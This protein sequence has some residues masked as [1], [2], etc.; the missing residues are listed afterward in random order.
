MDEARALAIVATAALAAAA[1]TPFV[2]RLARRIGAVDRPNER[3]VSRREAMPLMG[4]LAVGVGCAVGVGVA[5]ALAPAGAPL[6][7]ILGFGAG[8]LVVMWSSLRFERQLAQEVST[9]A[10][11]SPHS[12]LMFTCPR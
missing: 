11:L 6:E 9:E 8:A 5:L 1:T 10:T 2:I 7:R 3:K 4:G 12:R